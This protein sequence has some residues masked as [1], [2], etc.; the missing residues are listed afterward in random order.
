MDLM[1]RL[2]DFKSGTEDN[3]RDID[4]QDDGDWCHLNYTIEVP[5]DRETLQDA[6]DFVNETIQWIDEMVQ[7]AQEGVASF[8]TEL[9]TKY[10]ELSLVKL[11]E[12]IEKIDSATDRD[13]KGKLLEEFVAR[14]FESIDGI[15]IIERKR[16]KTE[17][18][19]IVLVNNAT[20]GLW[21]DESKLILIECKNWTKR[22]AGKNEYVAFREKLVNRRGR[23]KLGL[24]ISGKGFAKTF[25]LEDLRN[26]KD[27]IL[28]IPIDLKQLIE[29]VDKSLDLTEELEKLY[30]EATTK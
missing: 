23:A 2:A 24:F 25:Q 1:R 6:F 29:V 12:L 8:I 19:D 17:E 5:Q 26:S 27:D 16:T 10:N 21:K 28:I 4:F 22:P 11:P 20:E 15:R 14:L 9:T 18:I 30:V 13:E 7:T 3:I